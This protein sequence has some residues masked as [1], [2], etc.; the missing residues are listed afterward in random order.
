MAESNL[1]KYRPSGTK[2]S[3]RAKKIW[4]TRKARY[5]KSGRKDAGKLTKE[6]RKKRVGKKKAKLNVGNYS[7][8]KDLKKRRN[9]IFSNY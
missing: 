4:R 8:G 6:E 9:R 2:L 5:G 1:V 3:E 7:Y